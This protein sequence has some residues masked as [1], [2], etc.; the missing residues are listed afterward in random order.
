MSKVKQLDELYAEAYNNHVTSKKQINDLI[1]TLS[2]FVKDQ[3]NAMMLGPILSTFVNSSLKNDDNLIKLIN[4]MKKT[5]VVSDEFS[6]SQDELDDLLS[7]YKEDHP[8][9]KGMV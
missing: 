2:A 4:T 7:S 8:K 1:K 6:I 9:L 5:E 3:D